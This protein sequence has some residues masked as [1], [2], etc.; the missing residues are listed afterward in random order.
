[1]R[2]MGFLF[3]CLTFLAGITIGTIQTALINVVIFL[4]LALL[5][6]QFLGP[7]FGSNGL[8]FGMAGAFFASFMWAIPVAM[9]LKDKCEG[10][11]KDDGTCEMSIQRPQENTQ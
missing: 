10:G 5:V 8:A 2:L 7:R 9:F 6:A 1:M 4:G 11:L 3:L